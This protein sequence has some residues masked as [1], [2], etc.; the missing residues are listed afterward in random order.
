MSLHVNEID[1]WRLSNAASLFRTE[2]YTRG[3]FNHYVGEKMRGYLFN[4][5]G[6]SEQLQ[7]FHSE[8]KLNNMSIDLI[9]VN[10]DRGFIIRKYDCDSIYA[11]QFPLEGIGEVKSGKRENYLRPGQCLIVNP[12]QLVQKHWQRSLL[13]VMLRISRSALERVL[14][15]ELEIDLRVPLEF[16]EF[17]INNTIG[18]EFPRLIESVWRD[19]Y[20]DQMFQ[21]KRIVGHLERTIMLT[22][23]AGTPHNYRTQFDSVTHTAPFYVK[24][25]EEFMHEHLCVDITTLKLVEAAGVSERSLYYGF[26]RWRNTTPMSYLRRIRLER[27]RKDLQNAGREGRSITDVAMS[28]GYT[29]LSRFSKDY[30]ARFGETPSET[31]LKGRAG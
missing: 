3:E 17:V 9:Q 2:A 23:L 5:C 24:R 12:S 15:E 6:N 11:V 8:V 21:N 28:L 19:Y 4:P 26:K 22:L 7:F 1:K 16:D 18:H 30:K 29:H 14:M 13:Q 27:A 25:A 20:A 31:M 10:T